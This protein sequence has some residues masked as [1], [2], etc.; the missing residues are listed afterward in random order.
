MG[1]RDIRCLC[2]CS[3]R[4]KSQG[5]AVSGTFFI[6]F[7]LLFVYF[8][9][10]TSLD[11]FNISVENKT[12]PAGTPVRIEVTGPNSTNFTLNIYQNLS[13]ILSQN[14]ITSAAGRYLTRPNFSIPG[15]YTANLSENNLTPAIASTWFDITLPNISENN[16]T[17]SGCPIHE[18]HANKSAPD[19]NQKIPATA[20]EPEPEKKNKPTLVIKDAKKG[21]VKAKIILKES[22]TPKKG[23]TSISAS[24]NK[25][26]AQIVPE[27]GPVKKIEF[28]DLEISGD[29]VELGLDDVPETGRTGI[30]EIYAI[31]PT[32]LNFTEAKVTV[33]AKGYELLKCKDWSF[34]KQKCFGEWKKLMDLTPGEEYTFTLTPD[35]PAFSETESLSATGYNNARKIARDSSGN[36]Y[37]TYMK[38]SATYYHIYVSKSTDDGYTWSDMGGSA[39]ENTGNYDQMYPSIAVD[40]SDNLHVVWRGTDAT[41]SNTQIKY[42][43]Y[44]GASWSS[45]T[46]IQPISGYAQDYPSI[47]LDSSGNLHV[48]WEGIDASYSDTQIKYSNKTAS[49]WSDWTNIQQISSYAQSKPTIVFDSSDKLHI[50][51]HGKDSIYTSNPQIK[52]SNRT[53]SGWSNWI[54]IQPIS[55]YPQYD[56]SA[57]IDD[58]DKIHVVWAGRDSGSTLKEQI[59]YTNRTASDWA[60]WT[61]IYP[62]SETVESTPSIAL[63][64]NNT[65]YTLWRYDTQLFISTRNTTWTTNPVTSAGTHR[66]P[67]TRWSKHFNNEP[68]WGNTI[69]FGWTEGPGP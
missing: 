48:V 43:N 40:N 16:S 66:Y 58:S 8:T 17:P 57:A 13:L 12:N 26:K 45:W 68:S 1:K 9:H 31:D 55:G 65:P 54:N 69:D 27:I 33:T 50:L 3:S 29:T 53:A 15:R 24:K 36:I 34:E 2:D 52:Y 61:N 28:H 42:S 38:K 32:K 10:A 14:A 49:G 23:I 4:K 5:S 25:Y 39:I 60:S 7:I 18:S 21:T 20:N 56:A 41:Y 37:F 63:D 44:T 51:W 47:A 35:D 59:K 22:N 6:A 64:S 62:D 19:T 67:T 46:N 30:K 11:I